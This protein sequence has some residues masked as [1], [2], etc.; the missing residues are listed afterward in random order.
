MDVKSYEKPEYYVNRE[1]SW[2]KFNERVLSEAR[3]KTL[4]LFERLKFLSITSSNLDEFYMVRVASLKDQVH[5]KYTKADISGLTPREQLRS[6]SEKTHELVQVQY[7]T[8]NRSLLPT[9]KK[10]GLHVIEEH[11]MLTDAQKE[12][13][14]QYFEENVYPVLTPMAMDSS[15]PFPLIRNKTLN[16]GALIAKKDRKKEEK[17]LEFATVQVPSVLP[18]V[19]L[20]P[21]GKNDKQS[22]IFL[23]ELIERN[24]GKLF[25]N[26]D[27]V[28]AHPYRIMRNADLSIDE[29]EAEDL[30]VEIQ[31]QLK[32]R[33]WGEVIR[34]EVEEKMDSRLLKILK[35]EFEIKEEDIF[36][37]PG[38]LD[39]TVLMKLYGLDGFE[40]YKA[41]GYTPAPVAA[42]RGYE[43]IFDRIRE[44]DVFVHHP[45]MSFDPVVKF[46]QQAAKDP[47]VLAIKQTLYRVSGHSPIVAALAQAAENGKQVSV[48]VELKARF[49]EE[50]NIVWAK[51]LEKAGCHVIYGLVGLKTHSKITLV[52]RREENGIRRYVHLGTGNYNDSTAKLYTDCGIFTCDARIGEDA[53]AV[54]NML[55]GY[56]EPKYWNK[57]IVA[58]LWMKDRFLKMIELE[59]NHAKEGK[60]ARIMAKMNSLCDPKIM[61]ALYHASACGVK[62]ELIIRGIC[63]LKVG[64]PGVSENITVRSIVGD[65]LEHSR[66]FYFYNNGAEEVFMGSADWMPRNLDRRVEIVFPVEDEKI[67][68]EVIHILDVELADNRKAHILQPDGTYIKPDRRGKVLINSQ[69]EFC[70]EAQ[71]QA[72]DP[73]KKDRLKI[74]IP[75]EPAQMGEEEV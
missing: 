36:T 13:V 47:S 35:S 56:S 71:E 29:D 37:I 30:L 57:L 59:A 63:C 24:I 23:E 46:V 50:N 19:V 27:V 48:L 5:A 64:I 61:E 72:K 10:A 43:S 55:S 42:F 12:Y 68:R 66:I 53:T 9:L 60:E 69:Q 40:D 15:R 21:G 32:K 18:R 41:S 38:P 22:V 20:I 26:N 39:L 14:D 44:G 33:Q 49:D 28:C 7:S 17:I 45:Y 25:L 70:T 62:I 54:F 6:I 4:P 11:E 31:K 74:F 75:A 2:I 65:F 52:V 8:Y 67:K 34:L 58:P 51:K 1:L 73:G 3:D 16:I